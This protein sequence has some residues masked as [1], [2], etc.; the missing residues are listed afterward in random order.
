MSTYDLEEQEQLAALKAWWK[1]Y[2]GLIAAI[3]IIVLLILTAWQGWSWYQR[4][5]AAQAAS[6]YEQLQKAVRAS[7]IKASRDAAGS[8]LE[9]YP[10][11]IYAPLAAMLSAK[12]H[13]QSGDLKTARVQLQWAIDHAPSI[14]F[15]SIARLRL[16]NVL[17]DDKAPDDA[18][19]LLEEKSAEEYEALFS[20]ARGDIFLVQKKLQEAKAAY[21]SAL[22]DTGK[23]EASMRELVQLK[24]D[25][26]G[27]S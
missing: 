21:K 8:V 2:S 17:V 24:L 7:D 22:S 11:T 1:Q 27:E 12:I 3:M 14:Q 9:Q 20:I 13:Y 10:R 25:A 5:Q 15:K 23:L 26:L 19:K 4:T 6:I 16:A 18:A